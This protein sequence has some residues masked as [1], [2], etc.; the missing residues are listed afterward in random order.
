M[1]NA[2]I[3]AFTLTDLRN[4]T[5][6]ALLSFTLG[7]ELLAID[8]SYAYTNV[9]PASSG[10]YATTT[11][12]AY[13]FSLPSG[14]EWNKFEVAGMTLQVD[15]GHFDSG[16]ALYGNVR[17]YSLG[18]D[19]SWTPE[20]NANV[21]DMTSSADTIETYTDNFLSYA[22]G[23]RTEDFQSGLHAVVWFE[24]DGIDESSYVGYDGFNAQVYYAPKP[25]FTPNPL[26]VWRNAK[27]LKRFTDR[28]IRGHQG[29][30]AI[31]VVSD[32][33]AIYNGCGQ[34]EGHEKALYSIGLPQVARMVGPGDNNGSSSSEDIGHGT[35]QTYDFWTS[36]VAGTDDYLCNRRTMTA[37]L[38]STMTS[39][40]FT[41]EYDGIQTATTTETLNQVTGAIAWNASAATIQAALEALA[42]IDPVGT[43]TR[44]VRVV[45]G[46]TLDAGPIELEFCG[47]TH[48]DNSATLLLSSST[49]QV[50]VT[51][52]TN[53]LGVCEP[54]YKKTTGAASPKDLTIT[55]VGSIVPTARDPNFLVPNGF[56]INWPCTSTQKMNANEAIVGRWTH[57]SGTG[58]GAS[59]TV[60]IRKAAGSDE[61][62]SF[63]VRASGGTYTVT[64]G[65]NTTTAV[66]YDAS[67]ATL[68]TAL[69]AL[70]S[71]G[72][73]GVSVSATTIRRYVCEFA[74]FIGTNAE[75]QF[76]NVLISG[77][78]GL[79]VITRHT[80]TCIEFAHDGTSGTGYQLKFGAN[81]T[82]NIACTASAAT[83]QSALEGLASIGL[84]KVVVTLYVE[85]N[86]SLNFNGAPLTGTNV[87]ALTVDDTSLTG[88]NANVAATAAFNVYN[89]GAN[90]FTLLQTVT[91]S[92]TSGSLA[93]TLTTSSTLAAGS[94]N[95]AVGIS[96][97]RNATTVN[98]PYNLLFQSA[99][100]PTRGYGFVNRPLIY[101]GGRGLRTF[102]RDLQ[103]L[104]QVWF[105]AWA[106]HMNAILNEGSDGTGQYVFWIWSGVND[107]VDTRNSNGPSP[108]ASNTAAGFRDN[109]EAIRT[110]IRTLCTGAGIDLTKVFFVVSVSP[111]TTENDSLLSSFRTAAQAFSDANSD[112]AYCETKECISSYAWL[113]SQQDD[114]TDTYH[115]SRFAYHRILEHAWST[116]ATAAELE[117]VTAQHI[118]HGSM[119]M[120][121]NPEAGESE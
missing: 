84:G 82:G 16:V 68:Q 51:N 74:D 93:A 10:G 56:S 42:S 35:H 86:Y 5:P 109:L 41:L 26:A 77:G 38:T 8:L 120:G 99:S 119:A 67:A 66:A 54:Y 121:V 31:C 9:I 110:A 45:S 19:G 57:L 44:W 52:D 116:L 65:G 112:V 64:F 18:G 60:A 78:S 27:N 33:T 87:G 81:T 98:A 17:F 83:V 80:P 7:S 53:G 97:E 101:R 22:G 100:N 2:T 90:F 36:N 102:A 115:H 114:L 69:R 59:N 13:R 79:R 96:S 28:V 71:I 49:G 14:V 39:G 30:F 21:F 25:S 58:M 70:A 20:A 75:L 61:L 88:G 55:P 40:T 103:R 34:E 118:R 113:Q 73:T 76:D 63:N 29:R 107:S 23:L 106:A 48:S 3:P 72:A 24:M 4:F 94:R 108:A 6:S 43:G 62:V 105:T 11:G 95:Y 89:E 12:L 32:S 1:P 104:K 46:T 37:V 85:T 91:P 117:S 50:T 15:A 47:S 111:Q 92:L